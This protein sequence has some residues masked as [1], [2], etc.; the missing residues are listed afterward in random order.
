LPQRI[1][2]RPTAFFDHL[3]KARRF[4]FKQFHG[5]ACVPLATL[6]TRKPEARA[7]L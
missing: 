5:S 3:R 6:S 2:L 1:N 4:D 7:T